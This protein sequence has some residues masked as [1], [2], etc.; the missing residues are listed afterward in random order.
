M[1][2]R[3][4]TVKNRTGLHARPASEFVAK[5]KSFACGITVKKAGSEQ[6]PVNAKSMIRL[7][8]AGLVQGAQM[9]ICAE[10]EDAEQAVNALAE[11]VESGF[12]ED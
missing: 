7:L 1:F 8:A 3:V 4:V 9:E 12:G 5:A 2:K 6:E 11:L 10:G